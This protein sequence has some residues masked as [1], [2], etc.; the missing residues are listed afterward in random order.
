MAL[1][2]VV[3]E[4]IDI[5]LCDK[6]SKKQDYRINL[7][8][9][10]QHICVACIFFMKFTVCFL[11][12]RKKRCHLLRRLLSLKSLGPQQHMI[13]LRK[14]EQSKVERTEKSKY[15]KW[16]QTERASENLTA[17]R[18]ARSFMGKPSP[19][20]HFLTQKLYTATTER[21]RGAP[22]NTLGT[23]FAQLIQ[24]GLKY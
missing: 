5:L 15:E 7:N 20:Q 3:K 19:G 1:A 10:P 13:L 8:L 12:W 14:K 17:A 16:L 24:D 23:S 4:L 18:L 6:I 9:V 22:Y 2:G 21:V 11:F